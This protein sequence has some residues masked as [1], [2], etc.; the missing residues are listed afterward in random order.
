MISK[1]NVGKLNEIASSSSST[2]SSQTK[3]FFFSGRYAKKSALSQSNQLIDEPSDE[4]L[5]SLLS[6]PPNFKTL[7]ISEKREALELMRL[8]TLNKGMRKELYW[9]ERTQQYS[10]LP[11]PYIKPLPEIY[12]KGLQGYESIK[13][14]DNLRKKSDPSY[15]NL[16]KLIGNRPKNKIFDSNYINGIKNENAP[17]INVLRVHQLEKKKYMA[18]NLFHVN[19]AT[20]KKA[21]YGRKLKER[22]PSHSTLDHFIERDKLLKKVHDAFPLMLRNI[23][24][25]LDPS[26]IGRLPPQEIILHSFDRYV[27]NPLRSRPTEMT[28]EEPRCS[29]L[30]EDDQC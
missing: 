27:A 23:E 11:L 15:D 25:P 7:N 19:T 12:T 20:G 26:N 17:D 28:L 4:L 14:L 18:D 3:S 9:Q 24:S 30:E 6:L 22:P 29:S 10:C 5:S 13:P 1:N 16:I 21:Y 2:L 8:K